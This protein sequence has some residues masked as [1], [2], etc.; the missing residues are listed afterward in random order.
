MLPMEEV[1]CMTATIRVSLETRDLLKAQALRAHL[2]IGGYLEK[3]AHQAAK[4]ERFEELRRAIDSTDEA[5][6]TGYY[7]ETNGWGPTD[8]DE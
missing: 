8:A 5:Q 2:T 3:L 4:R 6:L 7:S 1:N